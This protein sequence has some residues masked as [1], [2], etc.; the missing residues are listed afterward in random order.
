MNIRTNSIGVIAQR[1]IATL[2]KSGCQV[3]AVKAAQVRPMIEI[4]YPSPEL[5]EGAIELKEQVNGLR[6]RSYAARLGGCI[7]H[8]HED[9]VREEFELTAGMSASEYIA[10]RAAGFPA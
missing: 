6:R 4:A 9:P 3:L 8:W 1:V 2:R 10:Y 7:V 5:K